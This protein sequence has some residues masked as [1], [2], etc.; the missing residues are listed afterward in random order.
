MLITDYGQVADFQLTNQEGTP[1]GLSNLKGSV[2]LAD[3]IFTRCMGPCPVITAKM[4]QLQNEF[5]SSTGLK[6]VSFSVDPEFDRPTVLKRYADTYKADLAQWNFLTGDHKKVYDTIR[7]NFHLVVEPGASE[8][9]IL[10]SLHIVLIDKTGTIRGYFVC[11]NEEQF[12]D[13]RAQLKKL[14]S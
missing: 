14:L 7:N 4:A 10:H 3:F 6:L 9:D 13:L 11:T 1:Y 5:P 8:T 12:A 2:W